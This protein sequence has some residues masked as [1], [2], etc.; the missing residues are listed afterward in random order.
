L[1]AIVEASPDSIIGKD[2]LVMITRD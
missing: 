1:A 2:L